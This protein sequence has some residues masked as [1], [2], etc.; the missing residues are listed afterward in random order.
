MNKGRSRKKMKTCGKA[1]SNLLLKRGREDVANN[2]FSYCNNIKIH[3]V[4]KSI[5]WISS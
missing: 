5:I 4:F 1:I 3:E 2:G